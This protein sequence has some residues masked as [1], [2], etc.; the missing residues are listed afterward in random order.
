[1]WQYR[2]SVPSHHNHKTSI[3]FSS[4]LCSSLSYLMAQS[5]GTPGANVLCFLSKNKFIKC[6]QISSPSICQSCI[7]GK[8]VKLPFSISNS[9]TSKP[10][11]IIHSDLW[12]SP[13]LSSAGHKYYLFFLDDYTNFVWTFPIGRKSQVPSIFS[14]F[15]AFIKIQFGTNIK[16][17]QC[18]NG[19]EFNNDTLHSFVTKM[20]WYSVFLVHTL[21]HKMAKLNVKYE[22]LFWHHS[23]VLAL[24]IHLCHHHFGIMPYKSPHTF[25]TFYLAR[26][27]HIT[28]PLN[29]YIK[30][31]PRTHIYVYLG[32]CVILSFPPPPSINC[33]PAPPHVPF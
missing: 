16:C 12:T 3:H 19:R 26:F 22:Q 11:D 29:T 9:T 13:I 20:V 28:P 17:F 10:F 2:W 7:Y 1:M 25:K 33:K 30:G 23:S 24:L 14:S 15:H 27:S 6:K 4:N 5:F 21:H 32:V 18:D 31:I 8:H